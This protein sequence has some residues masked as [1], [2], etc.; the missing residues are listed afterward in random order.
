MCVC[1]HTVHMGEKMHIYMQ[2]HAHHSTRYHLCGP[3]ITDRVASSSSKLQVLPSS[4]ILR[5]FLHFTNGSFQLFT[6][7]DYKPILSML[8]AW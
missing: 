4:W 1:V 8:L 2:V 3:Q 6:V 5:E 7:N